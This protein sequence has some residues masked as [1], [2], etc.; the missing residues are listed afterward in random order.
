M[1]AHASALEGELWVDGLGD[2]GEKK[3]MNMSCT[4]EVYIIWRVKFSF[5][6]TQRIHKRFDNPIQKSLIPECSTHWI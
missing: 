2:E 1:L 6:P 5:N 3:N 4:F